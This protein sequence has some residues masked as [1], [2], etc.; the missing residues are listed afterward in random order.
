M[1][2][3]LF[4]F[5]LQLGLRF[6]DP[7]MEKEYQ[8]TRSNRVIQIFEP[9]NNLMIII[10]VL[11]AFILRDQAS[12]FLLGTHLFFVIC[13]KL[14][15][16]TLFYQLHFVIILHSLVILYSKEENHW[17]IYSRMLGQIGGTY[18]FFMH[19]SFRWLFAMISSFVATLLLILVVKVHFGVFD[20]SF[21]A[22]IVV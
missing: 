19:M 13:Q 20:S 15:K 14:Y 10:F 2:N 4:K 11:L 1:L 12:I 6:S 21:I 18:I 9:F 5:E 8:E 17:F 22:A 7:L 16:Q 3:F